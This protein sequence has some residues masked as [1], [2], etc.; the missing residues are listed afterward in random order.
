MSN[1]YWRICIEEGLSDIGIIATKEQIEQLIKHIEHA[2]DNE[3]LACGYDCIAN[4]V[5]TE[6]DN[7]TQHVKRETE[8]QRLAEIEQN[9]NI[10][11]MYHDYQRRIGCLRDKLEEERNK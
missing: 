10:E 11:Q 1:E 4:P 6:L 5:K 3:S 8:K 7:L 9:K 2:R